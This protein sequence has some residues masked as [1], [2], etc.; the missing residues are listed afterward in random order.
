MCLCEFR[1]TCDGN[2]F[3]SC[4]GCGGDQCYCSCG[5]VMPCDGCDGCQDM[6]DADDFD[7][8]PPD[9]SHTAGES[10]A[11]GGER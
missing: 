6:P 1:D 11:P 9:E 7:D 4:D 5:G 3:L 8:G 10:P 2:G